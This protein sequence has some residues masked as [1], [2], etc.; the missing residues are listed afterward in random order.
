MRQLPCFVT[1]VPAIHHHI[2]HFSLCHALSSS[3]LR[4]SVSFHVAIWYTLSASISLCHALSSSVFLDA[5]VI[6]LVSLYQPLSASVMR[7]PYL[8]CSPA[9]VQGVVQYAQQ[10]GVRVMI[11]IDTPGHSASVSLGD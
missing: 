9:E 10:R 2:S 5:H 4:H 11:E 1:D 8:V 3:V 7:H 6:P